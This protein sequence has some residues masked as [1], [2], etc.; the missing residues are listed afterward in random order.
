MEWR[1]SPPIKHIHN[2]VVTAPH[3]N[4]CVFTEYDLLWHFASRCPRGIVALPLSVIKLMDI[5]TVNDAI[6]SELIS[7]EMDSGASSV[8]SC[9][10]SRVQP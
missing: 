3:Q 9:Q 4:L 2:A 7:S 5:E 8:S 1:P 6:H 10:R